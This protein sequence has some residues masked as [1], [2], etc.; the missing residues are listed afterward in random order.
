MDGA[1]SMRIIDLSDIDNEALEQAAFILVD[2]FRQHWPNAW[3]TLESART[4][5]QDALQEGKISRAGL[6]DSGRL[7]GW[8]VAI[9][10]Y[11]GKAWELH[12]LVVDPQHQGKGIGA[13][14]LADLED[15]V[16][17]HNGITIYLGT[18]DEDDMTS[19]SS[20]DR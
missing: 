3:P 14:L 9:S 5:V 1:K 17:R 6:D 12:P 20:V 18:D 16:K 15:Q 10:E 11:D 4:E 7:L 19:L 2:A 13:A 8:I